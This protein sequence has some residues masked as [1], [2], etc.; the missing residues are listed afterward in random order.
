MSSYLSDAE[1][2]MLEEKRLQTEQLDKHIAKKNS[3]LVGDPKEYKGI[4][5]SMNQRG[6]YECININT[7]SPLNGVFTSASILHSI[8]DKLE[9]NA[10]KASNV[11]GKGA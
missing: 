4:T 8:I 6:L 5:Y 1:K 2:A 10:S 9:A 3:A 11:K 7:T